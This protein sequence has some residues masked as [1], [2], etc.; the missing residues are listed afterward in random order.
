LQH[1]FNMKR[2]IIATT[3]LIVTLA[4]CSAGKQAAHS[5]QADAAAIIAANGTSQQLEDTFLH[6]LQQENDLLLVAYSGSV[7]WGRHYSYSIAARKNNVWR[8]YIYVTAGRV[9]APTVSILPA[10][11]NA[12]SANAAAAFAENTALWAGKDDRSKCTTQVSDGTTSYLV[13][14]AGDKVLQVNYYLPYIYQVSCPD[15]SRGLFL[16][17]FD[18]VKRLAGG[19]G[20][21]SSANN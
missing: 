18:K 15:S 10:S 5:P 12:D 21:P 17:V 20:A 7:A 3:V 14:A 19:R 9:N 13:M 16:Q 4:A 1:P 11:V 8:G 6:R 2:I